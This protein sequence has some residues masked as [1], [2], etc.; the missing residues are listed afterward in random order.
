MGNTLEKPGIILKREA[1]GQ[2]DEKEQQLRA[3]EEARVSCERKMA[4]RIAPQSV[5]CP[6]QRGFNIYEVSF[7]QNRGTIKPLAIADGHISIAK[8]EVG[9]A[10]HSYLVIH[11]GVSSQLVPLT[12]GE[13]PVA[14]NDM[15]LKKS[16]E[17][18]FTYFY[19]RV[20]NYVKA[21]EQ[22]LFKNI[23]NTQFSVIDSVESLW[24]TVLLIGEG[25]DELRQWGFVPKWDS[26]SPMEKL[27][28]YDKYCSHELN[29]FL[30]FKDA[31]FFREVVQR[32]I[33]NKKE[34]SVV[35]HFLLDDAA[36]AKRFCQIAQFDSLSALELV[37]LYLTVKNSDPTF[38]AAIKSYIRLMST[39]EK[40]PIEK[41]KRVFDS[42]L[43][44]KQSGDGDDKEASPPPMLG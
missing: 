8:A 44:S 17:E 29:L 15:S 36:G 18:G 19:E 24:E 32:F 26:F 11:D 10:A 23:Q 5:R 39:I 16:K 34:K 35:D 21:G 37:L 6:A 40:V 38:A 43:S 7:L 25:V 22:K 12:F 2:T 33:A 3:G 42:V 9:A 28:K 31:E 13:K 4:S 1:L 30:Y 41:H 14:K 27:Q 20:S